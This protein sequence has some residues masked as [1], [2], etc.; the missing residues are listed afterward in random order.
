MENRTRRRWAREDRVKIVLEGME[1]SNVKDVCRKYQVA[2]GQ[3]YRWKEAYLKRGE[4]G[5]EDHRF[6]SKRQKK[7]PLEVENQKLV[8]LVGRQ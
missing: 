4:E 5:L 7:N 1:S 2:P 3:W 6:G 8:E